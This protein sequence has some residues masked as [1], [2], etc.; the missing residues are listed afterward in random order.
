MAT[1]EL[2]KD[3]GLDPTFK[4]TIDFTSK[5]QQLNWFNTK[6]RV[7]YDNVNY[8][9]LQNT[10]KINTD[11]S[12]DEALSY[13][14]AIVS[15][16]EASSTRRYYC[17]INR[18]T[19]ISTETIEFELAIDPI[20]TFM[21]E[22]SI[23]ESMVT[24][25]HVDRWSPNSNYPIR[26]TPN[27][28]SINAN[29]IVSTGF[30]IVQDIENNGSGK[31]YLNPSEMGHC[32]V[33]YTKRDSATNT[34]KIVKAIFPFSK[35]SDGWIY[36]DRRVISGAELT[37]KNMVFPTV[38]DLLQGRIPTMFDIPPE[39]IVYMGVLPIVSFKLS[40]YTVSWDSYPHYIYE[41]ISDKIISEHYKVDDNY[42]FA[43]YAVTD[44]FTDISS[45]QV[46]TISTVSKPTASS[47]AMAKYEPAL[48]IEPFQKV[49]ITDGTGQIKLT[50]PEKFVMSGTIAVNIRT[51]LGNSGVYNI[52]SLYD[53][54]AAAGTEG[55]STI[56]EANY[57]DVFNDKWLTYAVTQRDTDRQLISNGNIQNAIDN[58]IFMSYGG[59]LVA[60]R[61]A[62]GNDT[63]QRRQKNILTGVTQAVGLAAGASIV[64][65][66]VDSHFAWENQKLNE[67][68]IKNQPNNLLLI[69]TGSAMI[70]IDTMH[71]HIYYVKCDAENIK[72][73]YQNFRKYGY[74]VNK[75]EVPDV[76][77]RKYFN[78]ILTD[79]CIIA[80]SLN[81]VI[82]QELA[83]IYDSG[84]T[85][86][87]GDYSSTL[88]YP[89][90]ENIERSLL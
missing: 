26:I 76:R 48:S 88:D 78:Y 8:N 3:I 23:G 75:F 89:T 66:L 32:I 57:M 16:I 1:V 30:D 19:L 63:T 4:K 70:N 90:A 20:Q 64:S 12:F 10:L 52:L 13:T 83:A 82:K 65:S 71:Y 81:T 7:T 14:Y 46:F 72:N 22:Y 56:I 41:N 59:S 67:T 73:H 6:S 45:K 42:S 15:D 43:M 9:K 84:I 18:V 36:G 62:S 60:S 51:L 39:D 80:G 17:F 2:Y 33:C 53:N 68:K 69:G 11:I 47:T 54:Y 49:V 85:I 87:H 5:S 40:C 79:G 74:E 77:S 35:F 50:I 37:Y 31:N 58:L 21:C 55:A 25:E 28:I 38:V 29:S 86:F 44:T 34:V 24:R 27:N 61:G